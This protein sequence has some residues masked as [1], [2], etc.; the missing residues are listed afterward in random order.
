[1]QTKDMVYLQ[2]L[3]LPKFDKNR[4]VDEHKALIFYGKCC[5]GIILGADFLTKMGIDIN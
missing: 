3:K 5:Y 4:Q 1:M 2:E